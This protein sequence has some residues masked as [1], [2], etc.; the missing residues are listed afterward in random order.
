MRDLSENSK[1][2][3]RN[4]ESDFYKE[5]PDY[6]ENRTVSQGQHFIQT[7]P[8][9][10]SVAPRVSSTMELETIDQA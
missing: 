4:V 9:S 10:L 2:I 6:P 7:D 1:P 3:Q 5:P 8:G